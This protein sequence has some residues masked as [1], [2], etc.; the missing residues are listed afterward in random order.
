MDAIDSNDMTVL[1]S[2]LAA[3]HMLSGLSPLEKE[4]YTRRYREKNQPDLAR[5][6][7]ILRRAQ[8]LLRDRSGLIRPRA[9]KLV[10]ANPHKVNALRNANAAFSKAMAK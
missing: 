6:L 1:S 10:G 9:D 7:T 8:E 4:M 5:Q 2:M 3:H